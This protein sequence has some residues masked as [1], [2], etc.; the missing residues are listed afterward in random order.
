MVLLKCA[1][2]GLVGSA[3]A[4]SVYVVG[5]LLLVVRP[6]AR[7]HGGTVGIDV[8]AM[9]VRPLFWVVMAAAFALGC[10]WEYRRVT[11]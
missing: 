10:V 9:L 2:A 4:V 1:L 7:H 8:R 6:I 11:R 5:Y 3:V